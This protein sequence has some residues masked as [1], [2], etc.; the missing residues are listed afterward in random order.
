VD[1]A[2][3]GVALSIVKTFPIA[4]WY[5]EQ[6]RAIQ[7]T[8]YVL[9]RSVADREGN[10]Y[11]QLRSL[12]DLHRMA[13]WTKESGNVIHVNMASNSQF[14]WGFV[15]TEGSTSDAVFLKFGN[16]MMGCSNFLPVNRGDLTSEECHMIISNLK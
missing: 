1:F 2:P 6:T 7:Q 5:L 4:S 12:V 15:P 10:Y 3:S 16:R 9:D 11:T 13:M 8:N 14:E